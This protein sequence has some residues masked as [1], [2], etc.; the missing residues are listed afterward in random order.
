[1]DEKI[2]HNHLHYEHSYPKRNAVAGSR[3]TIKNL[4]FQEQ[5]TRL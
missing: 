4:P 1:M 2:F 5:L 3:N